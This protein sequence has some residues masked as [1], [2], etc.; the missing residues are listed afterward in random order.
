MLDAGLRVGIGTDSVASNNRMDLLDE[1]RVAHLMACTRT[2][3]WRTFPALQA[4]HHATVGGADALRLWDRLGTLQSGAPADLCAFGL[5]VLA[6]QPVADVCDALVHGVAGSPARLTVAS[7]VVHVRDGALVH[8]AAHLRD[9]EHVDD[10]AR[11]LIA[12]RTR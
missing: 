8:A 7:G 10:M 4:L 2:Q 1:A 5:D 12:A 9:R 3:S 11:R 6:A